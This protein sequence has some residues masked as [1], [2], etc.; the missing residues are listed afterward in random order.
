M[1][2]RVTYSIG[3]QK[4]SARIAASNEQEAIEAV[5]DAYEDYGIG[6]KF[7]SIE[8]DGILEWSAAN[9]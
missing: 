2:Y 1:M 6:I 8:R 5:Y 3:S 9:R 7:V 4:H